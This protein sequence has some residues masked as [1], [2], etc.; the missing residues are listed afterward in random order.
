[1]HCRPGMTQVAVMNTL[2]PLVPPLPRPSSQN[3]ANAPYQQLFAD[4][5]VGGLVHSSPHGGPSRLSDIPSRPA[6][7]P[8]RL[9]VS[10]C[11]GSSS[12]G[13]RV[14]RQVAETQRLI[15]GIQDQIAQIKGSLSDL[16][17]SGRVEQ[18]GVGRRLAQL[19]QSQRVQQGADKCKVRG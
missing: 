14:D 12:A 2:A 5:G 7:T 8:N 3:A 10:A 15:A 1:M 13:G 19:E 6:A 17:S 4:I 11:S 18:E 9:T 16:G